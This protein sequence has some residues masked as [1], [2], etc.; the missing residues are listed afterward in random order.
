LL[1]HFIQQVDVWWHYQK[2]GSKNEK[3]TFVHLDCMRHD[4]AAPTLCSVSAW[5]RIIQC[6]ADLKLDNEHP[7]A[8]FTGNGLASGNIE[9]IC[10]EPINT[11]LHDAAKAVYNVMDPAALA[12]FSSHSIHVGACVALH[13]AGVQQQDIKFALWWKSDSFY[14]Y[15]QNLPCQAAC[16]TNAIINFHPHQFTLV[17]NEQ[18]A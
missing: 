18:A 12:R 17:P 14:A 6:W 10:P 11:A 8:I 1:A 9:F 15:L 3:K 16:A 5:V 13:A 4:Q 7:L 2:N